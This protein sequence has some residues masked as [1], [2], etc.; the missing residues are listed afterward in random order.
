MSFLVP[1]ASAIQSLADAFTAH[2]R[3]GWIR[4]LRELR[5]EQVKLRNEI[6]TASRA[7]NTTLIDELQNQLK[8]SYSDS[9]ALRNA[10]GNK[11]KEGHTNPN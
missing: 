7:A 3:N 8:T 2:A 11:S 5:Q 9:N 6:I 10:G 1:I 4:E